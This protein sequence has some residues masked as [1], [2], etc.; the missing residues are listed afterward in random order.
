[1][2][3]D[4][5]DDRNAQYREAVVDMATAIR[6]AF[7]R[8]R[9]ITK[10]NGC[11]QEKGESVRAFYHRLI[12]MFNKHSGMEEPEDRGAESGLWECFV[13]NWLTKGLRE[14]IM[15][16]VKTCLVGW[17]E[18]RLNDLLKYALHAEA[19]IEDEKEEAERRAAEAE[20]NATVRREKARAKADKDFQLTMVEVVRT[21][22]EGRDGEGTEN[23]RNF[24][25]G[26]GRYV[27]KEGIRKGC[28]ICGTNNHDTRDCTRCRICKQDGHWARQC[29]QTVRQKRA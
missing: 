8:R 12:E 29:P 14:D 18:A 4:W 21:L 26:R 22:G 1:E 24:N 3:T 27:Y 15:K 19:Q 6:E 9:E 10:M 11:I 20:R 16:K 13:S 7:P 17:T 25:R 23:Q 2:H 5:N 28:H